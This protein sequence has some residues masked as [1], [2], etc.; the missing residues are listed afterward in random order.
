[1]GSSVCVFIANCKLTWEPESL[2]RGHFWNLK[3]E[4]YLFRGLLKLWRSWKFFCVQLTALKHK[5]KKKQLTDN[6]CTTTLWS[7]NESF[8]KTCF[9]TTQLNFMVFSEIVAG[10]TAN[11][12]LNW[13]GAPDQPKMKMKIPFWLPVLVFDQFV[14]FHLPWNRYKKLLVS[15]NAFGNWLMAIHFN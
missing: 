12:F 6:Y 10:R 5:T 4:S 3:L 7:W 9:N 1:M 14:Y 8:P 15:S 13:K 11:D 2:L